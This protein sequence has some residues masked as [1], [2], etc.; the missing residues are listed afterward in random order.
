VIRKET[1]RGQQTHK[2]KSV[3]LPSAPAE[4]PKAPKANAA[5][6]MAL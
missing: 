6:D 1:D 4:K 2:N 3:P 5:S